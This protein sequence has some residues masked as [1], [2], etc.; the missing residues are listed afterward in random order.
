[1]NEARLE[2]VM[3]VLSAMG[4][5]LSMYLLY[6]TLSQ[7][8]GLCPTSG[9]QVVGASEYSYFIGLPVAFWGLGYYLVIFLVLTQILNGNRIELL[10]KSLGWLLLVGAIF[11]LY[12]RYLEFFVIHAI[13]FWCWFSVLFVT[14][15]IICYFLMKKRDN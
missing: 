10:K 2:K 7:D 9:C 8:Y 4:A 12:L 11:T 13:C 1:M 3:I 5:L 15:L 14:G 6:T